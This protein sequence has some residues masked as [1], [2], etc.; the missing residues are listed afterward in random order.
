MRS[1]VALVAIVVLLAAIKAAAVVFVPLLLGAMLAIAF[2]PVSDWLERKKMPAAVAAVIT[3]L[4]IIAVLVLGAILIVFAGGDIGEQMPRFERELRALRTDVAYWLRD[5]GMR[6]FSRELMAINPS[7]KLSEAAHAWLLDAGG[8][9]QTML[10][11]VIVTVFIQLEAASYR[12][13]L[14]T[15]M[16]G[17]KPVRRTLAALKEVQRYLGVKVLLSLANGVLLGLWCWAWDVSTPLLWGVLAFALNFIPIVGSV[18]A[19]VPPI[20]LALLEGGA[21]RALGV[22]SGYAAVNLVVDIFLEPRVMGRALGL[23]PLVVL[24]ALLI[25]G[26]VLGPVGALLSVPLTMAVKLGFEQADPE[27]RWIAVLLGT[28]EEARQNPS[29]QFPQHPSGQTP[30]VAPP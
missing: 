14:V 27:L 16:G 1:L 6:G 17:Q 23:S 3:V 19:A 22:A 30:V 12:K 10:M 28:G 29:G 25:W 2:I 15:V 24:L 20:A 4:S 11:V 18:L 7:D 21:G 26:F 9:L 5:H 8:L 13:K